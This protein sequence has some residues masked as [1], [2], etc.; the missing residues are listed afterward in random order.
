MITT[1]DEFLI[2]IHFGSAFIAGTIIAYFI[3]KALGWV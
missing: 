2:A 1:K 3:A